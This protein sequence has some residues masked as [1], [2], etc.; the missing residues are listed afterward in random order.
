MHKKYKR[1]NYKRISNNIDI[2]PSYYNNSQYKLKID[3][4]T[5]KNAGDGVFALEPIAKNKLIGY[6]EG[7]VIFNIHC[8]SY[9]ISIND[10]CGIN[11]ICYPR[12][13]MA[14]I[15]DTY[16]TDYKYNCEFVIN[17]NNSNY[18]KKVEIWSIND[19]NINDEL[20]IDYG[21]YYWI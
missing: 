16:K 6:Y 20:F 17:E 1:R 3:T 18:N 13:Y 21:N 12:C 9:Y 19:I 2:E 4:S 7:D 5:I 10:K 11:A 14:M 15:N 8:G